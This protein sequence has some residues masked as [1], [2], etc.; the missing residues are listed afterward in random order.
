[1]P[2]SLTHA[3]AAVAI[4]AAFAPTPMP[5]RYWVAGILCAVLPDLDAI[6]R[7]FGLGDVA[8]LGGHRAVT[9]SLSFA[10]AVG[11]IVA[12]VAFGDPLRTYNRVTVA[13]YL[14]LATASHGLLDLLTTYGGGVAL[15]SPFSELRFRS[16]WQPLGASPLDEIIYG[17]IPL[18]LII[19]AIRLRPQR[20]TAARAMRAPPDVERRVMG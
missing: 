7:P 2:S 11:V 12:L 6:G 17:L 9:H 8:L 1:M 20:P 4:G 15:L 18:L 16:P 19:W 14:A 3:A 10:I 13:A 5:R